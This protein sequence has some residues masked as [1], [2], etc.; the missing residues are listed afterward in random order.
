MKSESKNLRKKEHPN[1]TANNAL[2]YSQSEFE[3]TY[4]LGYRDIP[5][6][7]KKYVSGKKALDFGCGTGRSTRF[8]NRLGFNT[9]GLDISPNMLK[10]AVELDDSIHYVHLKSTEI[11]FVENSC[12]LVFSCFVFLTIS[13]KEEILSIF[14]EVNRCLKPGGVF[15]FVTASE[16]LYS[17]EWLS[18]NINCSDNKSLSS[19]DEVKIQL[20]DL[21]L[22]FI[23][24][25]WTDED[26]KNL[27]QL[28]RLT[29]LEQH[30]PLASEKDEKQW[31]SETKYPPYVTYVLQK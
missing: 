20:K 16:H 14:K 5:P 8:L 24:Y 26:Y 22:N 23:N 13:N 6:I 15:V 4:F 21:N 29:L 1:N 17:H 7:L 19:G 28:S 31:L 2:K 3:N 18:Y 12:D 27:F 11:P 9:V 25:Y 10:Q 30:F